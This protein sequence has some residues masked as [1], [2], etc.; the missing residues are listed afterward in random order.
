MPKAKMDRRTSSGYYS[1]MSNQRRRPRSPMSAMI[2][3]TL[4]KDNVHDDYALKTWRRH[5]WKG[6]CICS[7]RVMQTNTYVSSYNDV[8][9]N[10]NQSNNKKAVKIN[11]VILIANHIFNIPYFHFVLFIIKYYN[12]LFLLIPLEGLLCE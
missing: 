9:K 10:A 1:P 3:N 5:A 11:I 8:I 6:T 7:W 2:E 4:E 12:L